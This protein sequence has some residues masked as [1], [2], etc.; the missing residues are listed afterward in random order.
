MA[1]DAVEPN[2]DPFEH[3]RVSWAV[4]VAPDRESRYGR[5]AIDLAGLGE[6]GNLLEAENEKARSAEDRAFRV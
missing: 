5:V 3:Q 6:R 2:R 1:A 4:L